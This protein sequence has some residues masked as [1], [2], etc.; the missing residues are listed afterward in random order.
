MPRLTRDEIFP[1]P[2][3]LD[4]GDLLAWH[5][6]HL[7]KRMKKYRFE[8]I[9]GGITLYGIPWDSDQGSRSVMLSE[10]VFI[11][12]GYRLDG[13]TWRNA[14]DF[15]EELT[16]EEFGNL[17]TCIKH[18]NSAVMRA[19]WILEFQIGGLKTI[20]QC[21]T[22]DYKAPHLWPSSTY[23]SIP[24]GWSVDRVPFLVPLLDRIDFLESEINKLKA[25]A[26]L[27]SS[28]STSLELSPAPRKRESDFWVYITI[29]NTATPEQDLSLHGVQV[30]LNLD[31]DPTSAS[32]CTWSKRDDEA[33]AIKPN[34][35]LLEKE[36]SLR[37]TLKFKNIDAVTATLVGYG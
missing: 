37:L 4:P 28:A 5:K 33:Y 31:R 6:R 9:D 32:K 8:L 2:G 36:K 35:E 23:D 1:H 16:N 18:Y 27:V 22:F 10:S 25:V 17:A 24:V 3:T 7:L 15:E 14:E 13:E 20:E 11:L 29:K 12:S 34:S 19:S 21:Q 26:P 30:I